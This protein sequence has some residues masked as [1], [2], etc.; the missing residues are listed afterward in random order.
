MEVGVVIA[1]VV[2]VVVVTDRNE[3]SR[4]RE[5][6]STPQVRKEWPQNIFYSK[7][8]NRE[9]YYFYNAINCDIRNNHFVIKSYFLIYVIGLTLRISYLPC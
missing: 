1:V 8:N 3:K 5:I 6:F 2:V 7:I 9:K 4:F